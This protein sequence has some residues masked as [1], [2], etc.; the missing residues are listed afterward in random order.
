[1]DIDD[2]AQ[3]TGLSNEDIIKIKNILHAIKLFHAVE[4]NLSIR[5]AAHSGPS[6]TGSFP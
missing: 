6:R 4:D 1:M 2:I 5:K 3:I